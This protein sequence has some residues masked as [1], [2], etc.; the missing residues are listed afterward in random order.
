MK[1]SNFNIRRENLLKLCCIIQNIFPVHSL[2]FL[3]HW[4]DYIYLSSLADLL[5]HKG[6]GFWPVRS[7]YHTVFYRQSLGRKLIDHRNIQISVNNNCQSSGNGCRTHNQYIGRISHGCQ[8]LSLFHPKSVLFICDHQ[9]QLVILDLFLDQ[10]MGSNYNICLFGC[11]LC[12]F[13]PFLPGC[14]RSGKKQR[15]AEIN[16]L[17]LQKL[18]HSL[19]MLSGKHLCRR[20]QHRLVAI[21]RS[22][23]HS[24]KSQDCFAASHISLHQPGHQPMTAQVSFNLMPYILLGFCQSI[25]QI[26]NDLLCSPYSMHGKSIDCTLCFFFQKAHCKNKQQKL[27]KY[28]PSPGRDQLLH[29]FGK[30]N[31]RQCKIAVCQMIPFPV[32]LG[33]IFLMEISVLQSLMEQLHNGFIGQP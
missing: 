6:I 24:Q 28:Q 19:K 16:S 8:S 15:M 22:H 17:F 20:H 9:C 18:F 7:I 10:S 14:V 2:T 30:M 31:G 29:I 33:K 25:R 11:N 4:T 1:K 26:F 5:F 27:I 21:F 3:H 12:I 23:D 13:F 32:L